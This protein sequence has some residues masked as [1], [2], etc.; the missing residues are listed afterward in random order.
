MGEHAATIAGEGKNPEMEDILKVAKNAGMK[1]S[2]A[3]QIAEKVRDT[4][5]SRLRNYI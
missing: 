2:T 5:S 4:V 3:K 1:E